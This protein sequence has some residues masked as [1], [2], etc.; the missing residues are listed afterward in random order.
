MQQNTHR[1]IALA[2]ARQHTQR[3]LDMFGPAQFGKH[4]SSQARLLE[5]SKATSR[6]SFGQNACDLFPNAF[7]TDLMDPGR[8]RQNGVPGSL[9]DG[10]TEARSEADRTK[11][12]QLVF[13]KPGMWI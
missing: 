9:L 10:K 11:Y 1:E 4:L 12:S 13:L 7:V 6:L 3:L 5:H 8:H 2:L